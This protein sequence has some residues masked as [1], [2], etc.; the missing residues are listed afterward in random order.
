MKKLK[1]LARDFGFARAF[2]VALLL[3]LAALRIADPLPLEELRVRVF[4]LFQVIRPRVADQRPV[5]IIDIDEQS[6]R[7]SA[8]VRIGSPRH[9]ALLL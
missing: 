8:V 1:K 4:D 9:N 6:H 7:R 3:T 2:C 5:V